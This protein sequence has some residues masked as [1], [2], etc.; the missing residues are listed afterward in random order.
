MTEVGV[1]YLA[2]I[3]EAI[4]SHPRSQQIRIGPSEIGH[5]CARRLGYKLLGQAEHESKPNWKATVGTAIHEWLATVFDQWNLAHAAESAG[6][7]RFLVETKVTVGQMN[8]TD[9]DG[10]CDL[11]DRATGTVTDWKTC[12]PTQLQKYRRAGP[13]SQYRSQA[14][15]YGRGWQRAG[16]S[17]Q[18]VQ[19]VFLPRNGDLTDAVVWTE[20]YDENIAIAALARI[21]GIHLATTILSHKALDQLGTADA[22]C[23][24]CPYFKPS[25]QDLSQGCPGDAGAKVNATK[26]DGNADPL[27]GF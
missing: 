4:K 16:Y 17:V 12:G 23:H 22:W 18:A 2:T 9:V 6:Q 21:S 19:V 26:V 15:L 20:P 27:G 11:Y 1:E 14:H 25:S 3:T 5:P 10:S 8:G 7:E 13:G 24:L